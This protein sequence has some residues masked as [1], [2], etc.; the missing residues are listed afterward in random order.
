ML[1]SK[2]TPPDNP[3]LTGTLLTKSY[4][5]D[6][7]KEPTSDAIESTKHPPIATIHII[8]KSGL[9]VI[10]NKIT[11]MVPIP[12]LIKICLNVLAEE[13]AFL[14]ETFLMTETKKIIKYVSNR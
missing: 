8:K 12:P 6:F 1:P 5:V 14:R 10:P 13:F 11:N 2:D 9:S 4:V 3:F 7:E